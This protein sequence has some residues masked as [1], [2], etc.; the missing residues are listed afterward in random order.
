[1]LNSL[2]QQYLKA[3]KAYYLGKPIMSDSAFDIIEKEL[4]K[5][6]S[7][8]VNFVGYK[9]D[10]V[11]EKHISAMLSLEKITSKDD[12]N[13]PINEI[14]EWINKFEPNS[15]FEITPK[16]DGLAVNLIYKNGK[17]FKAITRGNG[18]EGFDITEKMKYI[19]P[20][21]IP[22]TE[23]IE[24][25]GEA[26]ISKNNFNEYFSEFKNPRNLVAGLLSSKDFKIEDISLIDFIAFEFKTHDF[27]TDYS[28]NIEEIC[29]EFGFNKPYVTL[30]ELDND[31]IIKNVYKIY[32]KFRDSLSH[33]Q[34]DGFVIKVI[35]N[36]QRR[37]LGQNEHHPK[38]AIAIKFK[39]QGNLTTVKDIQ[40]NVSKNGELIPIAILEP[41]DINGTT[42][43]RVSLYNY[44]EVLN[45]NI[46][47]NSIVRVEKMGDIIPK[48]TEVE[49][50][51]EDD[52]LPIPQS[53]PNCGQSIEKIKNLHL[54]CSN[55][56]CNAQNFKQFI[57]ALSSFNLK[58]IGEK[59]FKKIFEIIQEPIDLFD[60]TKFNKEI[61]INSG[62]FKKGKAL[63]NIFNVID[64]I[65]TINSYQ[66]IYLMKI[67]DIGKAIAIQ[68][69]RSIEGKI[70]SD[71]GLQRDL[72]KEVKNR[73]NEYFKLI[74]KIKSF[75]ID[76]IM[77]SD[78]EE[79]KPLNLINFEMT[80]KP[81]KQF[82]TKD[83]FY[84]F[85]KNKGYNYTKLDK[86]CNLLITDDINSSSTKMQKAKKLN[87]TI[88]TYQEI[89]NNI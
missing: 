77:A 36:E 20:N 31:E 42:V 67:M 43:S 80:G 87:I 40:W 8:I 11:K 50:S 27:I 2:E 65:K 60:K 74:D 82:K 19:V 76:V 44:G 49:Y 84:N 63:D 15:L 14:K 53:C 55:K 32:L 41:I 78:A 62:L 26:V 89:L 1:M 45:K 13:P 48:I 25:R 7:K 64:S 10:K 75:N 33:Y 88:K 22:F 9:I 68:I 12:N 46:K 38:W 37:E 85:I 24:I 3:K 59:I 81:P 5:Q 6:N 16:Y 86:N 4:K 47:I 28:L 29:E 72:F 54:I 70:Y 23:T 61:A 34:L 69:S 73:S 35:D 79:I 18:L 83:E 57:S 51:P 17:L 58:G 56:N 66:V 21:S 39:S 30:S 52:S 71:K